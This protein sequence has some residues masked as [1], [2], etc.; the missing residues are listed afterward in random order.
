MNVML[1]NLLQRGNSEAKSAPLDSDVEEAQSSDDFNALMA[2]LESVEE[3]RQQGKLDKQL[4]VEKA[5]SQLALD[6][7][8]SEQETTNGANTSTANVSEQTHQLSKLE[9][10]ATYPEQAHVKTDNTSAIATVAQAPTESHGK[11]ANAA[12]EGQLL[13]PGTKERAAT[14]SDKVILNDASSQDKAASTAKDNDLLSQITAAKQQSTTLKAAPK[15]VSTAVRA[16]LQSNSGPSKVAAD[17]STALSNEAKQQYAEQP[18]SAGQQKVTS[19]TLVQG[20]EGKAK[21]A[22]AVTGDNNTESTATQHSKPTKEQL[23]AAQKLVDEVKSKV[24]EQPRN[25]VPKPLANGLPGGQNGTAQPRPELGAGEPAKPSASDQ[26]DTT[27]KNQQQTIIDLRNKADIG[28]I[29]SQIQGSTK[30]MGVAGQAEES[31]ATAKVSKVLNSLNPVQQKE[32]QAVLNGDVDIYDA[33]PS[34]QK[35]VAQL[36]ANK[37]M[38]AVKAVNEPFKSAQSGALPANPESQ[39]DTDMALATKPQDKPQGL[40]KADNGSDFISPVKQLKQDKVMTNERAYQGESEQA[41][42]NEKAQSEKQVSE[43][44]SEK[45]SD[46]E[47]NATNSQEN[48]AVKENSKAERAPFNNIFST[49]RT[50][51]A[52]NAASSTEPATLNQ[53]MKE[54][55]QLQQSQNS[56]SNSA[57]QTKP[58]VDA[59]LQQAINIARHDAA[60][61]LNQRVG[62]MLNLN[63]KQ[64]EIRL[65]PPE[66]GALQIRIKSDAEQAQVN[67]VVQNQ[68]AKEMLEQS[69]PRLREM[70]AEQGIELGESH[71]S[72]GQSEGQEGQSD[73]QGQY[74]SGQQGSDDEQAMA[75]GA[76]QR[77]QRNS[78]S[79]IDYYA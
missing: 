68:Q 1:A 18:L 75:S 32:L 4:E 16:A 73:G 51:A 7:K 61:E 46:K 26:E 38:A 39:N 44:L 79:A 35:A 57:A 59:N 60:K 19:E 2:K 30:Q 20:T 47:F 8:Q 63:N 50:D 23:Q 56:S 70:L 11:E 29:S 9:Q 72:H 21:Q 74:G 62:M 71:I 78:D 36:L 52:P 48:A 58:T 77:Q 22:P 65:D 42:V 69:L 66:L 6:A 14:A 76:Q 28:P 12:A 34:V 15:E 31:N 17:E 45:L 54:V 41:K 43:K 5:A 64:A 10:N 13:S 3:T 33:S 49:T 24:T 55:Q 25:E 40:I 27:L 67:F 37:N 53:T